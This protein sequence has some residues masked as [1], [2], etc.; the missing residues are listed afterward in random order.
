M[1]H[2]SELDAVFTF[3]TAAVVTA[4]L[5]PLTMRLA[6]A[7]GAIDEPRERG[8]SDRPTP[9]LGG[10]AIFAG[11]LV[12]G[13]AWLPAG[14]RA[15]HH[16]WQGVLLGAGVITLVGALDDRFD[17]PAGVKLAGQVVAAVIVVHFGV[18]VK[19]VT[20]P[21]I[22]TLQFPHAGATNAGPILTVLGL[23][24]MM[25]VVNFSDGV[26]GLT[27]GVCVII[28]AT[29][30]VIAF[31]LGRSQPG[32]FAALTAGAALGFLV[33][34]FPP[35]SSFMGDCGA[36]LLGLLMG[37]IAVEAVVKTAAVV[38]FVLPLILLAV[39]FL[40]G[41]FV[42]LKRLKYRQP[43]YRADTEHFHHR[44]A[45][46][47]FSNRR[48][49]A[50]LYAWTLMLAGLALALRFVPYSNHK[51]HLY[52]GWTLVIVALGL[53]VVAASVYL[54]Y[55]LEIL[56]FRRVDAVRLRR[57]RPHATPAEIERGV[58]EDLETG[59]FGAVPAVE[60][61]ASA[62]RGQQRF[63]QRQ[64]DQNGVGAEQQR[65]RAQTPI[66]ADGR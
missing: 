32:V 30:A 7:A 17:L 46:I 66:A 38:S 52:T 48:T 4:V 25:N 20:L 50:Y 8:L 1:S 33:F 5:T 31:D 37:V 16:L 59:E 26:D 44:M 10:L 53:L 35:A 36:N 6:R 47:G 9:L 51:G 60:G 58:A 2:P 12:A 40:D 54:V 27:A 3:L 64:V 42:V 49:I 19:A 24:L 39:P 62:L 45:R 41:T 61:A 63:G 65:D 56:K 13:L 43:I 29:I 34:N 28:A 23:V 15:D 22:G 57:L 55:V 11:V 14:Y 18:A 21:F